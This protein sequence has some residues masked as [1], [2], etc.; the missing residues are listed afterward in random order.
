[1]NLIIG[2]D[3]LPV[4][5]L[6]CTGAIC[7]LRYSEQKKV[8]VIP[9]RGNTIEFEFTSKNDFKDTVKKYT[10]VL[11]GEENDTIDFENVVFVDTPGVSDNDTLAQRLYD[12][13]PNA[14][15]FMYI[16]NS[17]NDGGVQRD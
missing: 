16:L 17:T 3:I 10:R 4:S 6:Q 9:R 12:Y 11:P 1:M 8:V 14:M 13:L 5:A 7:R 2:D 15:A